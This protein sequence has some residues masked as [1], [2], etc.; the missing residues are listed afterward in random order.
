MDAL[1]TPAEMRAWREGRAASLGLVPTMGYL[2]EGHLALARRSL[3]ENAATVASIFVNPAQFGPG[4]DFERYPRDEARD[5]RLLR[6]LGVDAVYLPSAAAMYPD[7]Y[8]TWVT[9]ERTARRLEGASRP[10]HFRGVAT[11]VTKLFN[12]VRPDRAYFGRKDA[13]QLRL[14]RRLARDLDLPV[15]VVA[16]DTVREADGLAMSSRNAYLSPEDRAAAPVL[17]RALAAAA[18]RFAAGERSADALRA[19]ARAVLE[20]EPRA[21]IDYVS[22]ADSASLAEIEGEADGP[23][24][25]SL[26]ARFGPVRL[27]DNVELG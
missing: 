16:C 22:L 12:A 14:V 4:E 18:A 20:A 6:E 25:L 11:V 1:A 17:S 5:L 27:I 10:A 21:A 26:A 19:A 2:H 24:L 8:E 13:Q 9:V 7:G 15:D 3:A 23:A